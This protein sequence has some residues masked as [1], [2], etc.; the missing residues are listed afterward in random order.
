MLYKQKPLK[1]QVMVITGATSGIGLVTARMASAQGARLM[2]IARNERALE[3]L[4]GELNASGGNAVWFAADV[5]HESEVKAAAKKTVDVFRRFHTW[6]NN[7]GVS[8][9][10]KLDE[11][12]DEDSRRLFDTNFWGVV[13]GSLIAAKSFEKKGGGTIINIGS[14][15]SDRAIPIQGMYSASKHAVKGFTDALRMELE[16]RNAPIIVTL[17]KPAAIDTPYKD[18]ARNYMDVLP[19]NPA[20]VYAPETVAETIL[21]CAENP[22][23]DIFVGGGGKA[24]S[25]L[26]ELAPRLTDK[27]METAIIKM[28]RKDTPALKPK[29]DGLYTSFDDGL[30]ERGGYDGHVAKSSMYTTAALHPVATSAALAVGLGAAY[31]LTKRIFSS[32]KESPI[33]NQ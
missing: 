28:Q 12:A 24:L 30:R 3:A 4:C 7:A 32:P 31:A 15:L 1:K 27:L 8:I 13:N 11:V 26:G 25:T 9:Y 23:R 2:L 21:H 16:A 6:V 10:G 20:P 19:E 14:T 5:S 18:H 22:V 29:N 33:V 17:I